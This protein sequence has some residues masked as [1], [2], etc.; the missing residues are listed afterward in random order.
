[1]TRSASAKPVRLVANSIAVLDAKSGKPVG[2]V[3][4]GFSPTDVGAGGTKIWVLNRS[5]RTATAIDPS[6][7]KVVQTVGA[8]RLP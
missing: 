5:A 3:P 6:T 2:D 8:R 7:L 1:M 4:L